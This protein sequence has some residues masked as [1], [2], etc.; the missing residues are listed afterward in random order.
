MILIIMWYSMENI[1]KILSEK[2]KV[3][4]KMLVCKQIIRERGYVVQ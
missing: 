1:E 3:H 2:I 4:L